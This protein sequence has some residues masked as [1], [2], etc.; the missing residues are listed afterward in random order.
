MAS[1]SLSS[2]TE[3][4]KSETAKEMSTIVSPSPSITKPPNA[5]A[6][7]GVDDHQ[8]QG[9]PTSSKGS[10]YY[11][12]KANIPYNICPSVGTVK[13]HFWPTGAATL[14]HNLR[15]RPGKHFSLIVRGN[16]E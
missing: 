16:Y 13:L 15:A 8:V 3:L 10:R 7:G 6:F 12:N 4:T 9:T 1:I 5:A 2:A 11:Y 14:N